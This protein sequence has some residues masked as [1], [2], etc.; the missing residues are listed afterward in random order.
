MKHLRILFIF[1]LLGATALSAEQEEPPRGPPIYPGSKFTG[2]GVQ[3]ENQ[4]YVELSGD[5]VKP[6]RYYFPKNSTLL[7]LMLRIGT[8]SFSGYEGSPSTIVLSKQGADRKESQSI[9]FG[10]RKPEELARIPIE[11]QMSAHVIGRVL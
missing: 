8:E 7:D 9:R 3:S 11:D 10:G 1:M 6:G 4:I 2:F 5:V